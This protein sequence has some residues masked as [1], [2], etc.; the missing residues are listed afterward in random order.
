MS[1]KAWIQEHSTS[2]FEL[3]STTNHKI[4]TDVSYSVGDS[5][6]FYWVKDV[7]F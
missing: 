2:H 4:C 3:C 1:G 5:L 6:S 7:A